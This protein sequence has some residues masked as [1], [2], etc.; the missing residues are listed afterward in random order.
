M[1]QTLPPLFTFPY[2]ENLVRGPEV[3][4]ILH[5]L[6]TAKLGVGFESRYILPIFYALLWVPGLTNEPGRLVVCHLPKTMP[7]NDI[8]V[9]LGRF[10]YIGAQG[11][12][13]NLIS[14]YFGQ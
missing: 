10:P 3:P 14:I 5:R 8:A 2:P 1:C 4:K 12:S 13:P 6:N 9:F 7:L 11:S